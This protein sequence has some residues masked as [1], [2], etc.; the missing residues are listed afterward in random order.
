MPRAVFELTSS[1]CSA[2]V[3]ARPPTD[4]AAAPCVMA[5]ASRSKGNT[6]PTVFIWTILVRLLRVPEVHRLATAANNC[7]LHRRC[8]ALIQY[9]PY[10]AATQQPRPARGGCRG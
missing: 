4:D 6:R 3:L 8:C 5:R 2:M 7:D 1:D 10:A 9:V